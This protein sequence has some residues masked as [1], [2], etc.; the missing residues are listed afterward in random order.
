MILRVLVGMKAYPRNLDK[1]HVIQNKIVRFILYLPQRQ[2]TTVNGFEELRLLN[3]CNR[4]KQLRLNHVFNVF[5]N[6]CPKY[7]KDSFTR[8]SSNRNTRTTAYNFYVPNVKGVKSSS[9]CF[10]GVKNLNA[11]QELVKSIHVNSKI[12]FKYKVKKNT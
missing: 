3:V 2:Q 10:S 1:R 12:K 11:L 5:H 7:L 9:F 6:K 4:V 8:T